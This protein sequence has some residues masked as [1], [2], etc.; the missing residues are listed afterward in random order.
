[1]LFSYTMFIYT[2]AALSG[3]E[4]VFAGGLLGIALGLV[5]AVFVVAAFVS[6]NPE[7]VISTLKAT[8]IWVAVMLPIGFFDVP[9][10]LVAAFGAGGV[11]AIRMREPHDWQSRSI[12]VA[13]CVVWTI[14][15]R[16]AAPQLGLFAGAPLP[17]LAITAADLL[18]EKKLVRTD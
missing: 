15:L 13:L 3:D 12:A 16:Q 14:I 9:I 6:Q 17:F 4:V 18:R 11:V 7:T 10:A 8:G 5:P 2:L 1:M